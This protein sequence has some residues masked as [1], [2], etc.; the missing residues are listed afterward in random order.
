M[1]DRLE[2]RQRYAEALAGHAGSKAFF[3]DGHEWNHA[4]SA[5]FAHADVAI[6]EADLELRAQQE[7]QIEQSTE[8]LHKLADVQLE[9]DQLREKLRK[10]ERAA[11]LLAADHRAVERVHRRLD[12]WEQRLPAN[13]SKATVIDVL[14][15]DL[16]EAA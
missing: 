10:A 5:W 8:L 12:A 2:R 11:N 14:R 6:R 4:R 3:A 15:Q 7:R 13:V 1:T 16:D 9:N